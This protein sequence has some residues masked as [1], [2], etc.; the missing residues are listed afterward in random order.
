[1]QIDAFA[2]RLRPRSTW[3]AADL[4]VRLCQ[5]SARAVFVCYMTVFI[6]VALIAMA[7]FEIATWLPTTL[8]WWL[9]PWLD[10][11]ILFALSRAAFG[12]NTGIA[13]LWGAQREVWWRGLLASLTTRRLS[14]WRALTQPVHQLEGLGFKQRRKRTALIRSGRGSTGVLMT[15]AFSTIEVLM[16]FA[17]ISSAF[18]FA[19]AGHEVSFNNI[20]S[21]D[22]QQ[23]WMLISSAVYVIVVGL[24][25][26]FYVGAGFAMYLN[27]RVELEAWDIEQEFRRAF[28]Q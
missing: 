27:R 25:E 21:Q 15:G 16:V 19:P 8:L 6:P 26:P 12:V 2:I 9:K 28:A 20:I 13:D 1:M 5:H 4:G 7:S 14:P 10:R 18:W 24:L 22:F 3:E 23:T 17:L 11:S